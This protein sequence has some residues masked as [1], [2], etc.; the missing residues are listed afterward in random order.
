MRFLQ[1]LD[2]LGAC[3]SRLRPSDCQMRGSN[4]TIARRLVERS[5][6]SCGGPARAVGCPEIHPKRCKES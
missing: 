6:R 5:G 3:F 1:D 2:W 4:P